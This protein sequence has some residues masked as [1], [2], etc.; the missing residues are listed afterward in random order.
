MLLK[1]LQNS[2]EN[3][4]VRVSFFL[5]PATLLK[6]RLWHRCFP[7]NFAKFLRAPPTDHLR[8]LLL[9]LT[10]PN[11]CCMWM[12]SNFTGN[13][14]W[15]KSKHFHLFLIL[16]LKKSGF[17]NV[18]FFLWIIFKNTFFTEPLQWLL[19]YLRWLLLYF[20]K[21]LIEQL[22]RNLVMTLWRYDIVTL[23]RY[24]IFF[25]S[26]HYLMYKKSNSFVYK[27]VVSCQ[28]FETTPSGCTL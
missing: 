12:N 17:F 25:F 26:T 7:R 15:N 4:L 16:M 9:F 19:L 10:M 18:K 20:F 11:K 8:W 5:R 21:K 22:F 3:T 6:R 28:V 23:W 2:Q 27:F 1:I 24:D 14:S 13:Q